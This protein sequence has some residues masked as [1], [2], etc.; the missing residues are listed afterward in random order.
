MKRFC[1]ILLAVA[2]LLALAACGGQPAAQ[3]AAPAAEAAAEAE[4]AAEAGM[5]GAGATEVNTNP[6]VAESATLL[7]AAESSLPDL[8]G[9]YQLVTD[10][11]EPSDDAVFRYA[12]GQEPANLSVWTARSAAYRSAVPAVYETLFVWDAEA[13]DVKG[14]LATGYEWTDE[15]TLTITLREG[16]K[17]HSGKEMTAED[18]LYSLEALSGFVGGASRVEDID[19]EQSHTDGD[20]TLVLVCKQHAPSLL[21]QLCGIMTVVQEKGTLDGASSEMATMNGTGP[22]KFVSWEK[23]VKI[24]FERNEDYWDKENVPCYYKTIESYFYNDMSTA[25]MDFEV[26][27][28]D[29][30]KVESA[31]DLDNLLAGAYDDMA[32]L[33][34]VYQ[35]SIQFFCFFAP[36]DERLS[37]VRVRQAIAEA[38]DFN[39]II[40]ALCGSVYMTADGCFLPADSWA[41]KPEGSF[42]NPEHAAELVAELVAEGMSMEFTVPIEQKGNNI[43]LAEAMQAQ[44]ADVGITLIIE[45]TQ[46]TDFMPKMNAGEVSMGFGGS[47]GGWDPIEAWFPVVPG[48]GSVA[49]C[50]NERAIP[51]FSQAA[52]ADTTEERI[53]LYGQIQDIMFEDYDR[54][55]MYSEPEWIAVSN[56]VANVEFGQDHYPAFGMLTAVD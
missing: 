33:M 11:K 28:L 32:Y 9:G 31:T 38:V 3:E 16:V 46:Q 17:F 54:V 45:P 14:L 19:F 20:Y 12:Y 44:L 22:Y 39:T 52:N 21:T 49:E 6:D 40:T 47:F 18:V 13:N 5:V 8:I 15:T 41:Y 48:S 56:N 50:L 29:M 55:P 25:F 1:G 26:G 24:T 2:M 35:N 53:E 34:E 27:N 51:L 4:P 23:G 37:D 30:V 10:A 36:A 43:S 42:Y 7:S